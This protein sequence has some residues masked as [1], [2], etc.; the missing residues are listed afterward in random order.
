MP[1]TLPREMQQMVE[2]HAHMSAELEGL[3]NALQSAVAANRPS[4]GERKPLDE[5][6]AFEL[7]P[8]AQAEEDVIY[9]AG[10]AVPTLA[11]L[12]DGMVMEH[13]TIVALA[14]EL[15]GAS[16]GIPAAAAAKALFALFGVHVRKEN[17][18]LL[19]GLLE[20]GTEPGK[21]FA[22]MEHAFGVRQ[23]AAKAA[24]GA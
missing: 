21:L 16:E 18:L 2:H 19:P 6:V 23:A 22:E 8:H 5:F 9:R 11:P 10:S 24:A 13:H 7:V 4:A 15:R 17:E 12:V 3:V 20:A 14:G 1:G